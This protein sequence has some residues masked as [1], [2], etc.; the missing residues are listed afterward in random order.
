MVLFDGM[1]TCVTGTSALLAQHPNVVGTPHLGANTVE[2]QKRVA[3]EI[4]EQFVDAAT[5]KKLTGIVSQ[6]SCWFW[7]LINK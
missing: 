5:G 4:A 3:K 6:G 7:I 2:A 1:K